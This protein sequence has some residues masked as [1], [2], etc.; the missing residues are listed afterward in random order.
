MLDLTSSIEDQTLA[1]PLPIEPL[2]RAIKADDA[3]AKA[4]RAKRH[5]EFLAERAEGWAEAMAGS[6]IAVLAARGLDLHDDQRQRIVDE[7]SLTQLE[8][9]VKAA[10]I[11]ATVTELLAGR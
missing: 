1:V 8:R 11:C 9:W 7:R 4:L 5:P 6:V 3:V 2:V 10:A